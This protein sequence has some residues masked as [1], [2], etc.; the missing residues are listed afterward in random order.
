MPMKRLKKAQWL[1][2]VL[3]CLFGIRRAAQ[4]P[5]PMVRLANIE[6]YPA[7]LE[8]YRAALR[9]EIEASIRLEPGVRTLYAVAEKNNPTRFT[10]LEIYAD[11]AAYRAHLQTPHFR[12]YKT[13]TSDMVKSLELVAV[14]AL[15]P[16]MKI[17]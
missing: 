8:A 3:T 17:K 7:H 11:S 14:D 16:G 9:E 12:K 1:P 4:N 6:V 5:T 15:V 2:F 13:G 10:I